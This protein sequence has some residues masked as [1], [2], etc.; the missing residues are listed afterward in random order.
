M[1]VNSHVGLELS[2]DVYGDTNS[3]K[4]RDIDDVAEDINENESDKKEQINKNT[5]VQKGKLKSSAVQLLTRKATL[6]D[7]SNRHIESHVSKETS[8]LETYLQ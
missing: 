2:A 7:L 5:N 3:E 6:S 1:N 4:K 8:K